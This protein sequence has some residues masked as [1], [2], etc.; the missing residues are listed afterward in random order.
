MSIYNSL[1]NKIILPIGTIF[2]GG[3]YTK[4]LKEWKRYD[5]KNESELKELQEER[6]HTILK[7]AI[8]YVP[9]YKNQSLDELKKLSCV[10]K[11]CVKAT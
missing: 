6:L 11:R 9:F 10:N 5:S 4:Y 1:L 3:S 7:Y 2:F 8:K